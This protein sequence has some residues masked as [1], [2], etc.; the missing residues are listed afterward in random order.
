MAGVAE[1]VV[2]ICVLR[3]TFSLLKRLEVSVQTDCTMK[4][5]VEEKPNNRI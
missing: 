1:G 4:K 3:K 5:R 2:A